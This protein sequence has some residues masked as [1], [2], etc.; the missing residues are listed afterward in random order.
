MKPVSPENGLL[1]STHC[2]IVL[3]SFLMSRLISNCVMEAVKAA[4]SVSV[5]PKMRLPFLFIFGRVS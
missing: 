4:V 5:K 2:N 3:S 1:K